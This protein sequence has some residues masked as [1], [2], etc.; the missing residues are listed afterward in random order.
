MSEKITAGNRMG[1]D[2][3]SKNPAEIDGNRQIHVLT[4]R[5]KLE[6]IMGKMGEFLS[7]SGSESVARP[8]LTL[9]WGGKSAS[10]PDIVFDDDVVDPVPVLA[11]KPVL[12]LAD[13]VGPWIEKAPLDICLDYWS[14]WMH[15]DDRDL[16]AKSQS[17]IESGSDD[18]DDVFDARAASDSAAARVERE[19]AMATDAM[20]DSLDRHYKAAIYRRCNVASVWRFPNL[21]F[22][23]VLPEAEE[24]LIAKL[25][26]NIATRAF[27]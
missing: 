21:D 18:S 10:V 8:K 12:S 25:K 4:F 2:E 20:I 24:A 13:R 17:G 14:R 26:K 9:N 22:V 16:G 23:V 1:E 7:A 5:D 6:K 15:C 27:F 19:V 3:I 11:R